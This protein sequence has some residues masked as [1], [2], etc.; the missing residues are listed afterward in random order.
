VQALGGQRGED[1][2]IES[3]SGV[4]DDREWV[5]I[6]NRIEELLKCAAVCDVARHEGD[7][8]SGSTQVLGKGVRPS[9]SGAVAGNEQ[10]MMDAVVMDEVTSE[11]AAKGASAA[12][13]EDG[14]V[15][16]Q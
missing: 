13:N 3:A 15:R 12:G 6:G 2:V 8:R 1:G 7:V 11:E 10:E 4:D 9:G 14:A 5:V 16:V